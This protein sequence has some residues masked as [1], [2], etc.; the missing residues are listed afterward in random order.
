MYFEN[1]DEIYEY[2]AFSFVHLFA[3]SIFLHDCVV[4]NI[5]HVRYLWYSLKSIAKLAKYR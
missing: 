2:K 4:K 5:L 1:V 3:H